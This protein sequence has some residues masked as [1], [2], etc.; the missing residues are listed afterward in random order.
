MQ[1]VE[2]EIAGEGLTS[3]FIPSFYKEHNRP[4]LEALL[5]VDTVAVE[6]GN[7]SYNLLQVLTPLFKH[8]QQPS[9]VSFHACY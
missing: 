9:I 4:N 2:A 1:E 7:G 3:L 6:D 5:R 8:F